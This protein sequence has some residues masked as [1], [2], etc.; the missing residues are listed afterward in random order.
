MLLLILSGLI[1]YRV[2]DMHDLFIFCV[3]EAYY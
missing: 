1:V 2:T 3:S